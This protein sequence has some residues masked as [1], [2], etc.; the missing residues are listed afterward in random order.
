[1]E[2]WVSS[3]R[4]GIVGAAAGA[5]AKLGDAIKEQR[6]SGKSDIWSRLRQISASPGSERAWTSPKT[7]T[8][9]ASK[10][11]ERWKTVARRLMISGH[12]CEPDRGDWEL[13]AGRASRGPRWHYSLGAGSET[14]SQRSKSDR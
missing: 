2:S 4:E 1:M 13:R 3:G 8:L 12:V 10:D 6:A 11:L 7:G 5:R 14:R 9:A